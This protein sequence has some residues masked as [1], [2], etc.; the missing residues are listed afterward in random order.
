MELSLHQKQGIVFQSIATEILF[1]GAAGPGKSHLMRVAAI[2]WC[3]AIPGLQVYLFRR[4]FPDLMK[5]HMEGPSSFRALLAEWT[6]QR[7]VKFNDTENNITFNNGS[8]IFLCHCQHEKDVYKYQGAEI[9]VLMIDELTHFSDPMYRY[10]RGRVRMVG[11]DLP[12][13]YQNKFPRVLTASNPGGVGHNWVKST[14]IDSAPPLEIHKTAKSE[15]GMLRQ[16]VPA[17]MSDNPALL[18]VDPEYADR[19]EGLGNPELVKAMKSGLW[20]ILAGGM[21]DDLFHRDIHVI[22]PFKIPG[23]WYIDRGFDW[24]SS[25]PFSVQWYAESDG[26]K[27]P[28]GTYYPKG[29]IFIFHEYYG[30]VKNKP[31]TGLKLTAAEIAK[32]IVEIEDSWNYDVHPGPAD[33]SIYS[34]QNNNCI[35][36]DMKAEGVKWKP[37]NNAPGSRKDGWEG[38]R[39]MLKA[40]RDNPSEEPGLYVFNNC[41]DWI[42]TVPTLPRDEKNSEDADTDAEDHAGDNTRYRIRNSSRPAQGWTGSA[43]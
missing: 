10:L 7:V 16:F 14:F 12:P 31:N 41:L 32:K 21:F 1:G 22:E 37:A 9:H 6:E 23:S 27:A 36:D 29:T 19:L 24:G 8:K 30:C 5:N 11:I 17:V 35:A 25:K 38:V 13:Q 43:H 20:D 26:T 15:G 33:P 34:S 42:R 18:E 40:A 2:A 4:T 3:V 39:K 28:N